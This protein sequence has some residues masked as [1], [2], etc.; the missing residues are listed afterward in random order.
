M[1]SQRAGREA[2]KEGDRDRHA[3]E[4]GRET[5][6]GRTGREEEGEGEEGERGRGRTARSVGSESRNGRGPDVEPANT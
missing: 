3:W 4:T 2:D 5:E 6:M 1:T